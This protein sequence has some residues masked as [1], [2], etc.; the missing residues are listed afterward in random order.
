M[1]FA[2]FKLIALVSCILPI[3]AD[4]CRDFHSFYTN[5]IRYGPSS[6]DTLSLS[7]KYQISGIPRAEGGVTFLAADDN[8]TTKMYSYESGQSWELSDGFDEKITDFYLFQSD[9]QVNYL[10]YIADDAGV[11][12]LWIAEQA[13]NSTVWTS[14]RQVY[15]QAFNLRWP[16]GAVYG[17]AIWITVQREDTLDL[18][19]YKSVDHG[20]TFSGN[21]PVVVNGGKMS[22]TTPYGM[23]VGT[24]DGGSRPFSWFY[25]FDQNYQYS[26][27][28]YGDLDTGLKAGP[29]NN[30]LN[31]LS[32]TSYGGVAVADG[33]AMLVRAGYVSGNGQ[34]A[35]TIVQLTSQVPVPASCDE[36]MLF[37]G[38]DFVGTG[39]VPALV[40]INEN[41]N[42]VV[43]FSWAEGSQYGQI[44]AAWDVPY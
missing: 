13:V 33:K 39:M 26:L 43:A 34:N 19:Y 11:N 18:V 42:D 40:H 1:M 23:F 32:V 41:G 2:V 3:L 31:F 24:V 5:P 16:R 22:P 20:A 21:E 8:G 17:D 37:C 25:W 10:L 38:M 7:T 9:W 15:K 4:E 30:Q 29:I 28:G 14:K 36:N 27:L 35:Y 6:N 44:Y 12:D